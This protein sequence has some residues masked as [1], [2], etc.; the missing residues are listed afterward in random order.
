MLWKASEGLQLIPQGACNGRLVDTNL[1]LLAR[2]ITYAIIEHQYIHMELEEA[3][4][5]RD[6]LLRR[7]VSPMGQQTVLQQFWQIHGY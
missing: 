3:D 6:T 7:H 4:L 5:G 2:T 1:L